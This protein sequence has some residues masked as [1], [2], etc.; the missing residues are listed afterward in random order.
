[1]TRGRLGEPVAWYVHET[2]TAHFAAEGRGC[3]H[4]GCDGPA[5]VASYVE[6]PKGGA[7]AWERLWCVRHGRQ[8]ATERGISVDPRSERSVRYLTDAAAAAAALVDVT[9]ASRERCPHPSACAVTE[10]YVHRGVPGRIEELFCAQHGEA[11]A[12][13]WGVEIAPARDPQ[14]TRRAARCPYESCHHNH[15]EARWRP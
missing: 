13:H 8:W 1:M 5:E 12:F 3:D 6:A 9:C 4:P 2:D 10:A 14:D 7:P 11:L 15:P